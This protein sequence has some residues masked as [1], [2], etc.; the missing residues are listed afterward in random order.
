MVLFLY[1]FISIFYLHPRPFQRQHSYSVLLCIPMLLSPPP[2]PEVGSRCGWQPRH[3]LLSINVC[4]AALQLPRSL[5]LPFLWEASAKPHGFNGFQP[6]C[7]HSEVIFS[8]LQLEVSLWL[9]LI[10]FN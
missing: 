5:A 2:R 1:F 8:S 9:Y 10:Y 6:T 4:C 3:L 7:N